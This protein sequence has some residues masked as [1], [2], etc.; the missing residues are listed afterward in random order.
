MTMPEA[1][2]I[3]YAIKPGESETLVDWIAR[4][5]DRSTEVAEAM[6]EGGLVA[7]AVFL[8]RSDNGDYILIYTSTRDLKAAL[9]TLSNSKLPLIQ[10]FNQLMVGSLE[11]EHAVALELVYHTP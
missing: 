8:E 2:C 9:E 10:E 11:V 3:K 7:E 6:A 4:L 1:Q 5:E